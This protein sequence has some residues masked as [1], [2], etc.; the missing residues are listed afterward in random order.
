MNKRHVCWNNSD[1]LDI[2]RAEKKKLIYENMGYTFAGT[3]LQND[4]CRSL[5]LRKKDKTE[6]DNNMLF[7]YYNNFREKFKHK[8]ESKRRKIKLLRKNELV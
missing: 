7:Q 2:K 6:I 3:I 5:Y 1:I 4:F 8:V